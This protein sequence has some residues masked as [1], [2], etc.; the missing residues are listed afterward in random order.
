MTAM[1][2]MENR[3]VEM[4][5]KQMMVMNAST[6]TLTSSW[7]MESIPSTPLRTKMDLALTTSAGL[8]KIYMWIQIVENI[9]KRT[10]TCTFCTTQKSRWRHDALVF[11]QKRPKD[12]V[13][14]LWCDRMPWTNRSALNLQN[15]F[16][17]SAVKMTF[18]RVLV[19]VFRC[20]AN[21]SG[22]SRPWSHCSQA[23]TYN[24]FPN[25]N[26]QAHDAWE[27]QP[28]S[29][30]YLYTHW[31]ISHPQYHCCTSTVLHLWEGSAKEAH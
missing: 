14:L 6:G 19:C 29:T 27:A 24:R 7:R 28:G 3:T 8:E 15:I 1:W 16:S 23:P 31:G 26:Y 9:Y 12:V 20:C 30:T 4:W 17:S 22:P 13:G 18:S 10:L 5:V 11:L 21:R 25:N 2:M